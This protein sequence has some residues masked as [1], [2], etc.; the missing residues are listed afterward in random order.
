MKNLFLFLSALLLVTCGGGNKK[1]EKPP[2]VQDMAMN[3]PVQ[4]SVHLT[5]PGL[6]IDLESLKDSIN[7]NMDISKLSLSDVRLLRN[8]FSARQGYC[9]M[10]AELRGIFETTSWYD[11]IMND[12]FW[13]EDEGK[14]FP[15]ITFTKEEQTFISKLQARENE[16]KKLNFMR[17]DDRI[18]P[19]L[20]N[21]VNLFQMKET[22]RELMVMLAQ[23]GFAIAPGNEIQ[24]FHVYEQNDYNQFPNFVTTDMYLQLF[25]MY[26]GYMLRT[27]EEEQFI[28]MLSHISRSMMEKMNTLATTHSDESIREIAR[29]NATF[30]AIAYSV[31]TDEK[32]SV[33]AG[34]EKMYREEIKHISDASDAL[35]DFLDYK[36]VRFPYS[37][38]KPRGHYTR[39]EELKRYFRAMMWLQT[40]PFC[41]DND[42]HLKRAVLNAEV[43]GNS[44]D[45]GDSTLIKYKGIL[46]PVSFI[47]GEP[48]NV[49]FYQLVNKMKEERLSADNILTNQ[50]AL[51]KFRKEI[52][53]LADDRNRIRPKQALSCVDKIN[54]MPQRY[55]P[56]NEILQEMVDVES[57]E[58]KR[59]YPMGLDIMAAFG[60]AS[61]ENILLN[62]LK[63]GEKW[64][65]YP[66]K[67]DE[68]KS[69]MQ[70][71]DWNATVYNKWIESLLNLQKPDSK[72]PYFMQTPQW[73]KKDLNASLASWAEL[74]HDAILYAEQPMA[75][76]C[77]G[78]G[79]PDPY[80]VGYV[81]PNVNY[82]TTVI[83]L[84]D[85]TI[86]VLEQNHLYNSDLKQVSQ[87][88]RENAQFLLS[89]SQKE[90]TG[91]KLSDREYNEIE[92]I[93]STYEWITLD[94]VKQ[95]GQYLD[96]W[97]NVQGPDK[98]VAVVADVYTS[99]AS[100]NPD[101]GILHEATGNVNDIY[102][103]VEIEGYLYLTRGAVLEYHEFHLPLGNRLTDEEWQQ[104][105]EKNQ[106]QGIPEWI[107]EIIVPVKKP[108]MNQKI[109]YSSGC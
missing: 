76:E 7:L 15:P 80:T 97:E 94:L 16:L 92:Y 62:E 47:I 33:P 60:S 14:P 9:F 103:V 58:S 34:Y 67:L 69:K 68:M 59:G 108:E 89:A 8:A 99:N 13:A 102:V 45:K 36:D 44:R 71:V 1:S 98:S 65:V 26:F 19:N 42:T 75:A 86:A 25:H 53:V 21:L 18:V 82:W 12:R 22:P 55:L 32:V 38:F 29:Y 66:E 87:K 20:N 24:L 83:E 43:L 61:A 95:K 84:I 73:A 109:F 54:F 5:T 81:E 2:D 4:D 41:L 85:G 91:E 88:L 104:M 23:N 17:R 70:A 79:P 107:K 35:S 39:T 46:E 49:S 51:E 74:K 6:G 56:D 72:Y 10:K 31:L 77:G 93:G 52:K 96:G 27:L 28:P 50:K 40:A 30:Y 78:G 37:L 48:D 63:E 101:K 57:A 3:I 100:N 64:Q 106:A 11:K 90:L 105:L